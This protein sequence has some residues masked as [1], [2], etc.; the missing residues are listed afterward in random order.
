MIQVRLKWISSSP[1]GRRWCSLQLSVNSLQNGFIFH[2][3][4]DTKPS[5][6]ILL[7]SS[8][9]WPSR[10]LSL[11]QS[12]TELLSG[13]RGGLPKILHG[14]PLETTV[15]A[16]RFRFRSSMFRCGEL[17]DAGSQRYHVGVPRLYHSVP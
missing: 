16:L 15:C 9:K 17:D 10:T 1:C 4:H 12:G 6:G 7:S 5:T 11:Q 3:C 8:G 14:G 2:S 13:R